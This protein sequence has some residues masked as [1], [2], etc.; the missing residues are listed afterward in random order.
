MVNETLKNK[1]MHHGMVTT[2][3][4]VG[5]PPFFHDAVPF[6]GSILNQSIQLRDEFPGLAAASEILKDVEG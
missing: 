5:L 2:V 4:T 1:V 6:C 3:E